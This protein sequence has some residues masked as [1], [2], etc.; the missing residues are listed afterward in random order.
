MTVLRRN[1]FLL[2]MLCSL[3]WLAFVGAQ[4]HG[5]PSTGDILAAVLP[6]IILFLAGLGLTLIWERFGQ[7]HWLRLSEHLRRG[8]TRLYL[9]VTVPWVAWYGYKVYDALQQDGYETT[10]EVSGAF[11]SLLIVPIGGPVLFLV[12]V[13]VVAGFQKSKPERPQSTSTIKAPLL[14]R[15]SSASNRLPHEYYVIINRAVSKLSPNSTAARQRVYDH[16]RNALQSQLL[17]HDPSVIE[18]ERGALEGAIRNVETIADLRDKE[19][20]G[21]RSTGLL[22][23]SIWLPGLWAMDFT[24]MSLYWVAR[25][26]RMK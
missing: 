9:V 14:K 19:K 5:P 7:R 16:A 13:W 20:L 15:S 12:V 1:L 21:P 22:V 17:N 6:P 24:S 3:L 25:L 23:A 26:P 4:S 10:P 18:R 8:I 11:W 2:W